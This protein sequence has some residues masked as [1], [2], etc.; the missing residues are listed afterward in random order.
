M[1]FNKPQTPLLKVEFLYE[2]KLDNVL[3]LRHLDCQEL[4]KVVALKII[5]NHVISIN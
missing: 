2:Y 1:Y 5:A 3:D 4:L